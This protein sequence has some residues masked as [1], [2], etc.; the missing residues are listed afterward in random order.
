MLVMWSGNADTYVMQY[1]TSI[2]AGTA[3]RIFVEVPHQGQVG[4]S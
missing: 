3:G 1:V 4:Q 2:E